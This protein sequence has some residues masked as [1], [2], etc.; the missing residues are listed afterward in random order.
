MSA[1]I[2]SCVGEPLKRSVMCL[3][4]CWTPLLNSASFNIVVP[5]RGVKEYVLFILRRG[6]RAG[7]ELL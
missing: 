6:C 2:R 3:H 4:L 7:L 5:L 1:F